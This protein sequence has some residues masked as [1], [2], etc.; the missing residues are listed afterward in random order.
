[1][2]SRVKAADVAGH[3]YPAQP[4]ELAGM[5][6]R[7]LAP[8]P[9][10]GIV[11]KAVVAPHA[12]YVYSGAVAGAAYRALAKRRGEIKR[13]L[14]FGPAHRMAFKGLAV[15]RVDAWLT[16]LGALATDMELLE[17]A[18]ALPEV[19]AVDQPF[20]GEHSLE[21]HLPFIRQALGPVSVLP[22][23]VGGAAPETVAKTL[24]ALW[25][26]PDT[27]I[28]ISSDLS[29]FLDYAAAGK[30]DAATSQA[31]ERA[32]GDGL[33]GHDACGY[34]GIRGLLA[35]AKARDLRITALD[36]R[37][38]GDT[39]GDKARVVGYGSY[40]FEYAH[41][42]RLKDRDRVALGV[43]ARD[44]IRQGLDAGQPALPAIEPLP[45]TLRA[46]RNSFVTIA[47]DGKLRGCIGSLRP[48]RPLALDV[49]ENAFRAAFADP[50][51]PKLSPAE[52]E[53][54]S[55]SVSIL[56]HPRPIAAASED[57]LVDR[58][59]PDI[60]G[61]ILG[62]GKR[63]ALFLPSVWEG[64]PDARQFTRHLRHKAGFEPTAWPQ[65]LKAWRFETESFAA[66]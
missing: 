25:G 43:L 66:A 36:V 35:H 11:P 30:R 20:L 27:A 48:T 24:E 59:R 44:S 56:S 53:R 10:P 17:R 50:R 42:A 46:Q 28:V 57:E 60:D 45:C 54:L 39:A 63:Q 6:E 55:V 58:L 21:V 62:D 61:L 51:F 14:L 31:I 41:A 3:F 1:M 2:P 5:L 16:P 13:V 52:A 19:S 49:C 22:I 32:E 8:G 34:V 47:I 7:C 29:H 33:G 40:A 9:D 37:N 12:G 64:L 15:L 65:G 4:D 26:G 23:L 38:S 18:L